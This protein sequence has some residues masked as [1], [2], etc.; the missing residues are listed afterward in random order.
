MIRNRVKELPFNLHSIKF[1]L[2][3]LVVLTSIP[4]CVIFISSVLDDREKTLI[5][6]NHES[7]SLVSSIASQQEGL[8]AGTQQLVKALG[9][10]QDV[11]DKK[12]I[13]PLNHLLAT[14]L[15]QSTQYH[16]LLIADPKGNILAA[17]L[18]FKAPLSISERKFF[19][20]V[21]RTRQFSSGEYVIGKTVQK[22][23]LNFAYPVLDPAGKVAAVVVVAIDLNYFRKIY[24]N[25]V[26][27][28]VVNAA[29]FD[30]SGI[31]LYRAK[32]PDK[33]IGKQSVP[34][35]FSRMR[36]GAAEGIFTETGID[37]IKKIFYYRKLFVEGEKEP[38]MY[39][40]ANFSEHAA[41]DKTRQS[42]LR[43]LA[44][45]IAV[46][47]LALA[48]ALLLAKFSITNKVEALLVAIQDLSLGQSRGKIGT[49]VTGGEFG[50]L[51]NAFDE[52]NEQLIARD[53]EKEQAARE[54][55]ESHG[56]LLT[57]LDSMEAIVYVV[58]MQ[59]YEVLFVNRYVQ[60][61]FGDITGQICWKSLQ[62]GQSGPCE[63]CTNNLLLDLSGKP[64]PVHTWEYQ[65]QLN[66]NWYEAHDRAVKWLDGR[67]VRLEIAI[68]I[69]RRKLMERAL[70]A[71]EE[72]F[73]T[74]CDAA[75]IGIFRSDSAGSV[76]YG[77]QRWREITGNVAPERTG[78]GWIERSHPDDIEELDNAW[79]EA[80]TQGRSF[81]H[82]HRQLSPDGK[83][84]WV[85]VL[86]SP[87]LNPDGTI[88]S[89]VGT[90]EDITELRQ[91][92][93]DMLKS[94][95]LESLG[96][97]AGGIAHDFN[98]ILTAV[99]GNVSL[100]RFQSMNPE[101]VAKRLE[102]AEHAITRATDLTKQLLTFARG[103]EPIKK[104]VDVNE[105]LRES[106]R[107][108][109]HGSNVDCKFD[110][111]DDLW[112][113]EADEGQLA[114]VI[115]NLILN[116]VQAMPQGG[117]VTVRAE[118]VHPSPE[119]RFVK[120]SITDS[121]IGIAEHNL[122]RIFDPYFTTKT[123]GNGLGLATCY[124]IIKKH[125]GKIRAVSEVGV[126][127]TFV[128]SLPASERSCET[129][130]K[131]RRT[132]FH[133]R[134]RV[135]VMDDD[136]DI[137]SVARNI[138]EVLGYTVECTESGTQTVELYQR[139]QE[140][141][142]PFFAVILDVTIPGGVGGKETIEKLLTLDPAVK[143][144]VSSGYSNDPL[145]ANY[146]DYGFQAVLSKPYL[147]QEMSRVLHLLRE[148]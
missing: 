24:S 133:S 38:Y 2:V 128:I 89:H 141:G 120:I 28:E 71:S 111:A 81:S 49:R 107:F 40:L 5:E 135:L 43:D 7:K 106:A 51:A 15:K 139:H 118:K 45:F 18:P 64:R 69:T 39:I 55:S 30:H 134:G 110:L 86:A 103:G 140:Q 117:T 113:V 46:F 100:A 145:M 116:G 29:I 138:L 44:K 8:I 10:I 101:A 73:R 91:A 17:G 70:H 88:L 42:L 104:V 61:H 121:G 115:H 126:G 114:Q 87:I 105:L 26:F 112:P 4:F 90:L 131:S 59:T 50:L 129:V 82:E 9:Q 79:L 19:R 32:E 34:A 96:V 62:V 21:I 76:I 74:L 22:P 56:R 63:F 6:I 11:G 67:L 132:L 147:P 36:R 52:M 122:Q 123:Q 78:Q 35:V 3:L 75:P 16:N 83:T 60:E 54:I 27:P 57:V 77:N 143:A 85:R 33:Y 80:R 98:N 48:S 102:D 127:S 109:L 41:L 94:Q 72:Q 97:L 25:L 1:H 58:D 146:L 124:S 125:G 137:R 20:E 119:E 53:A 92:R 68:D 31:V 148:A 13:R 136:K 37:G 84:I 47:T 65:S 93:Q 99:F 144:V 130:P 108:V 12:R 23:T 14:L 66:G 142:K 95:K